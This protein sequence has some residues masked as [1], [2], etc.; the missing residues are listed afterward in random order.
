MA[1]SAHTG[2]SG[3]QRGA[4]ERP[5]DRAPGRIVG[6]VALSA[7]GLSARFF[8]SRYSATNGENFT[9]RKVA[10][11]EFV[12]NTQQ[13]WRRSMLELLRDSQITKQF[14]KLKKHASES[15]RYN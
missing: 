14:R 3:H 11:V 12:S 8:P 13:T 5:T 2:Q 4:C 9:T 15:Y 7:H 6:Y 10:H 1:L